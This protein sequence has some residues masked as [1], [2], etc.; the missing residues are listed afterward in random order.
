MIIREKIVFY[1]IQFDR[2]LSQFFRIDTCVHDIINNNK[3]TTKMRWFIRLFALNLVCTKEYCKKLAPFGEQTGLMTKRM[4][5]YVKNRVADYYNLKH[6]KFVAIT[7]N[8]VT[9]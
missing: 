5:D 1:N 6:S 8:S 9:T 3:M 4:S 2:I 7:K